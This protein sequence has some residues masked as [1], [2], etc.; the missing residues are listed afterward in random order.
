[1]EPSSR[2]AQSC[3]LCSTHCSAFVRTKTRR[4]CL[5]GEVFTFGVDPAVAFPTLHHLA[6]I[7]VIVIA[8]VTERTEVSCKRDG[9]FTGSPAAALT[10]G[11]RWL[12][13]AV[14]RKQ[15]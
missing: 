10:S 13:A 14:L 1:M 3:L 4:I 12:L 11:G 9:G 7:V 15:L 6:L 8:L 2:K 5:T